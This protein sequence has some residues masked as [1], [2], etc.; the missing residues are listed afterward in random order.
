MQLKIYK[1]LRHM[2]TIAQRYGKVLN[3]VQEF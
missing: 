2:K 1:E 3:G